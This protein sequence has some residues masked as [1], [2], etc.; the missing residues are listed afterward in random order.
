MP[1]IPHPSIVSTNLNGLSA[2]ALPGTPGARRRAMVTRQL[3][4][5]LMNAEFCLVQETKLNP[6]DKT[7]PSPLGG[8]V[9]HNNFPN[10]NKRS[11]AGTLII[12]NNKVA[13]S[14][15]IE[16]TILIPGYLQMLDVTPKDPSYPPYRILNFYGQQT[17][18]DRLTQ[19]GCIESLT[20]VRFTFLGGDFNFK[21]RPNQT[22]GRYKEL[23]TRFLSAWNRALDKHRHQGK[24]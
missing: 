21:D 2:Y 20:P 17:M 13:R 16:H 24:N 1:R 22:T 3:A 15:V 7:C 4:H 23:P 8:V 10:P 11:N 6:L 18:E 12:V 19:V 9:Y 5:H 14:S